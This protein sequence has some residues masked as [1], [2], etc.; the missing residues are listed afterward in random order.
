MSNCW[1]QA[2]HLRIFIS[3]GQS[4]SAGHRLAAASSQVTGLRRRDD[5]AGRGICAGQS[6]CRR[7]IGA[8]TGGRG[9]DRAGIRW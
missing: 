1:G 6:I 8:R 3:A 2:P 4:V 9:A 7:S 5:D